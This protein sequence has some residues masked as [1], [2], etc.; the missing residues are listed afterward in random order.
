MDA[1]PLFP[2]GYGLSYTTFE[3]SNLRLANK[4]LNAND[5]LSISVNIKNTGQYRGAETIQVYISDLVG[6]VTRPVKELKA[7]KRIELVPNEKKIVYF[8]IPLSN[9]AFWDIEMQ[10]SIEP[11]KFK[12]MIG[13]NSQSGLEAFFNVK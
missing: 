3:Y 7:F 11:G 4:I 9:L 10:K 1:Q 5:T 8:R 12:I 6:S 13:N 2:F